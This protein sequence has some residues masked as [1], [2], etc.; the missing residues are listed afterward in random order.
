[1]DTHT[2]FPSF[3]KANEILA[4]ILDELPALFFE[5]LHGG[6]LLV[7]DLKLHPESEQAHPL[8]IM[9]EYSRSPLGNQIKIYFGSFQKVHPNASESQLRERLRKTLIH[10]FTHHLEYKAGLKGLE[11]EDAKDLKRYRDQSTSK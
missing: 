8:Y 2:T 11:V 1:M 5:E 6:I 7:P 10:E 3:E 4:E 9:G